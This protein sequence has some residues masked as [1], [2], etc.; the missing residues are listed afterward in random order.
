[1]TDLTTENTRL[2]TENAGL[3]DELNE[4]NVDRE[5]LKQENKRLGTHLRKVFIF[6]KRLNIVVGREHLVTGTPSAPSVT[7][8]FFFVILVVLPAQVI[9]GGHAVSM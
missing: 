8:L 2:K 3:K 4:A 1:M 6:G 5:Y 9:V 7:C